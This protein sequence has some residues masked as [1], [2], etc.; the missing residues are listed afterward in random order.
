MESG[1][2]PLQFR[3][4]EGAAGSDEEEEREGEEEVGG[5]FWDDF[6]VPGEGEIDVWIGADWFLDSEGVDAGGETGAEVDVFDI[7]D[8]ADA[9]LEEAAE[10]EGCVGFVEAEIQI[11]EG[12]VDGRPINVVGDGSVPCEDGRELTEFATC[13]DFK[14]PCEFGIGT[15]GFGPTE[16]VGKAGVAGIGRAG[17]EDLVTVVNVEFACAVVG[18]QGLAVGP[19]PKIGKFFIFF[20]GTGHEKGFDDAG[21]GSGVEGGSVEGMT[22]KKGGSGCDDGCGSAGGSGG[23]DDVWFRAAS[24]IDGRCAGAMIPVA[25]SDDDAVVGLAHETG[26]DGRGTVVETEDGGEVIAGDGEIH[27]ARD[28]GGKRCV[29]GDLGGG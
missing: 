15:V 14:E 25:P 28:L 6:G 10:G 11:G 12:A 19:A 29:G 9:L 7:I 2:L 26:D 8:G 24:A 3:R 4:G 18:I 21:I 23:G 1:A 16:G 13:D 17:V 20:G 22:P 27:P 5:G